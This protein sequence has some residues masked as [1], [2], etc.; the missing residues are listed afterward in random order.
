MLPPTIE[1]N[2]WSFKNANVLENQVEKS[3]TI[4]WLQVSV[5]DVQ[6]TIDDLRTFEANNHHLFSV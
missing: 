1:N 6:I 3:P 4:L 5:T 2:K